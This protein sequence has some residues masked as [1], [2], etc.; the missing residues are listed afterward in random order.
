MILAGTPLSIILQKKDKDAMERAG[1][2]LKALVHAYG[3]MIFR[4]GLFQ[5][6]SI[7]HYAFFVSS[8]LL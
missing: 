3:N 7:P 4:D 1:R 2:A 5:V 6:S 8:L